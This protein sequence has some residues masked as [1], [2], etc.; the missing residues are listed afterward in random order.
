MKEPQRA[1]DR[2]D[3]PAR[4]APLD[5]AGAVR[6]APSRSVPALLTGAAHW[7]TP[8]G[9]LHQVWRVLVQRRS[10]AGL[11]EKFTGDGPRLAGGQVLI[12]GVSLG[13][14]ALMRPLLEGLEALGERCV[15]TASTGTGLHGVAR[16]AQ[17]H[18]T[19]VLPLDLPGAVER[20][21]SRT[22]PRALLLLEVEL[23]PLLLATCARRGIP[24]YVV[25]ARM[26]AGSFRSY[27]RFRGL[28]RPALQAIRGVLAQ[29]ELWAARCRALGLH[30]VVVTGSLKADVVRPADETARD[31]EAARLGL[32]PGPL[33]SKNILLGASTAA[34]EEEPI[35]RAWKEALQPRGWRL[36]LCPRHPE[37]GAELAA[38]CQ[39]H[40]LHPVRSSSDALPAPAGAVLIVD[41]IGRLGALYANAAIAVV[42]GSW[43]SGRGGQNMLEAAAAGCATVVGPDTGN[44]RDGMALLRQAGGVV[45]SDPAGLAAALAA[46]A[47]DP[48]HRA[49]LGSAGQR[50]WRAGRGAAAR[51]VQ[52]LVAWGVV[53]S[54]GS[55]DRNDSPQGPSR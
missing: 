22:R 54:G 17:R 33:A 7:L 18:D 30:P 44:Q 8:W 27:H 19:A 38:L 49:R 53:G 45:E 50:A 41:E 31:A 6:R 23:W 2:D 20:F 13:E 32:P 46:L 1:V 11:K 29:N 36:V 55:G 24:V 42:G 15:L 3:V 21:L 34:G 51:T 25:N 16:Y 10:A 26:G 43:G 47:A 28:L 52:L 12:H 48:A 4:P 5:R 9:V 37:R 39:R 14:T 35:I 40:G